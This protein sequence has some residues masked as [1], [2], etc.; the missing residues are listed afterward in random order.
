WERSLDTA[1]A[2]SCPIPAWIIHRPGSPFRDFA[3]EIE[4]HD[5]ER[6][7]YPGTWCPRCEDYL[8]A[9]H[10]ALIADEVHI[11]VFLLN[12]YIGSIIGRCSLTG[13]QTRFRQTI[14]AY[15]DGHYDVTVFRHLSNPIQHLR[16][17]GRSRD[18]Y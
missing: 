4:I 8:I 6:Q 3:A 12:I 5:V 10:P 18:N 9:L 16:R 7:V 1:S 14:G 13:E 15:A 17:L 11:R 2:M